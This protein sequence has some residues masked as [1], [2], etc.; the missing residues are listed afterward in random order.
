MG[1]WL[2][3]SNNVL[4][5]VQTESIVIR[6]TNL[7]PGTRRGDDYVRRADDCPPLENQRLIRVRRNLPRA[8]P[9]SP[10]PRRT[11]TRARPTSIPQ[12]RTSIP[13]SA[14]SFPGG[15]Q[16][17]SLRAKPCKRTGEAGTRFLRE[18]DSLIAGIRILQRERRDRIRADRSLIFPA[19]KGSLRRL[20]RRAVVSAIHW[21]RR[22]ALDARD[23]VAALSGHRYRMMH[24]RSV[25]AVKTPALAA[26]RRRFRMSPRKTINGGKAKRRMKN[27][28]GTAH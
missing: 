6:D 22:A 9:V 26:R 13:A 5:S 2:R 14:R 28:I 11:L 1:I 4:L 12:R 20:N 24:P 19:R 10:H 15:G 23:C 7:A 27:Q 18:L 16:P 25:A 17:F 21:A 8:R 3:R